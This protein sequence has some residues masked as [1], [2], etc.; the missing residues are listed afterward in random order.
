MNRLIFD[1]KPEQVKTM[2]AQ[3]DYL[4]RAD[5]ENR[6]IYAYVSEQKLPIGSGA[7]ES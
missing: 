7:I 2:I 6:L 1:A 3:R 4:V 5:V